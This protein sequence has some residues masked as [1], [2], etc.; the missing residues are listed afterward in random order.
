MRSDAHGHELTCNTCHTAHRYDT[1]EA[2]VTACLNCHADAHSLAYE[3]SPHHALWQRELAGAAEAG[4][5][6]SCATCHMPRVAYDPNDWLRRTLVD[7]NQNAT[8][9]PN[10]K[11]IRP[12]CLHC[13][14]LG[15][16]IDALADPEL[17][18]RNFTGRPAVQVESM[19]MAVADHERYLQELE[20]RE[21]NGS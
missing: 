10:E 1:R 9:R 18:R 21:R 11:M 13:H 4:T 7:H 20:A 6:V 19:G 3:A 2:A 15:F 8:L 5:G 14:G 17:V 16:A 12:V